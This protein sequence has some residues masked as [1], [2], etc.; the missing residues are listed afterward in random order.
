VDYLLK[1]GE[2]LNFRTTGKME[3]VTVTSGRIWLTR[4]SDPRD[5]C[6]EA[7]A[8]LPVGKNQSIFIEAIDDAAVS[9]SWK[10]APAALR[11]T[12]AWSRPPLA[13][14]R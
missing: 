13:L 1:K 5:Y 7:G 3:A 10:A 4:H 12:L 6:L 9:L 11:I 14:T 2:L 8:K